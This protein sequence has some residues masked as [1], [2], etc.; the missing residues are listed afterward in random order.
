[1]SGRLD[2]LTRLCNAALELVLPMAASCL[3]CGDPRRAQEQD[4][5]CPACREALDKQRLQGALCLR[6]MTPLDD[7]GRCAFC[8]AKGLGSQREG[9]AAFRHQGAA[10][11]LVTRLKFQ[12]C[13]AAAL[14]LVQSM[15][16]SVPLSRYDALVPVPLHPRRQRVRGANQAEILCRGLSPKLG[17]PVL[18]ALRRVQHTR[19]Q[20]S[21]PRA[22][23][24]RNV[25]N[26]FSLQA[27]VRGLRL[28]LVDDVR[29]TGATSRACAQVL[30]RGGAQSV[31]ILTA[32]IAIKDS[33]HRER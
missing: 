27:D 17:M 5:L 14:P 21:L 3:L 26:A 28:L 12:Y 15:A 30:L 22:E 19:E 13:D 29:T 25:Q 8:A 20:S 31:G 7:H 10:R 11:R 16:Q 32:T 4:C 2:F 18:N 1:M 24:L 9:F 33:R 6:C 23:R